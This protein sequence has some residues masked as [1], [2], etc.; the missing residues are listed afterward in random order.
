MKHVL[1]V[2]TSQEVVILAV[3]YPDG[4]GSGRNRRLEVCERDGVTGEAAREFFLIIDE[5]ND[6]LVSAFCFVFF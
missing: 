4:S 5:S 3:T 6:H 2:A 1:A